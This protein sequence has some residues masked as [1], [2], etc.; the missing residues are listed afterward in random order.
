MNEWSKCNG[1]LFSH[2]EEGNLAICSE[3]DKA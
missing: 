2:E 1:V 3:M